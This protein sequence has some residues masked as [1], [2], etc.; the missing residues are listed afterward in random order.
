ML[1]RIG[2]GDAVA[3]LDAGESVS[4]AADQS[5]DVVA[6]RN[7]TGDVAFRD[8]VVSFVFAHQA[9]GVLVA[10]DVDIFKTEF[11]DGGV[12]DGS[13]KGVF[14]AAVVLD[15]DSFDHMTVSVEFAR[16]GVVVAA[17]RRPVALDCDVGCKDVFACE[18]VGDR[19]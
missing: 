11:G 12:F 8:G 15:A 19:P 9:A 13:D 17:E 18:V 7:L 10:E 1:A 6:T 5:A 3:V 16:E 2:I 14:I 4:A